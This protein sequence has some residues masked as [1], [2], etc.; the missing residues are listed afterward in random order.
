[1]PILITTYGPGLLRLKS[2]NKPIY[3]IPNPVDASIES[4]QAFQ[5]SHH[6]DLFIALGA[7]YPTFDERRNTIS[8]IQKVLPHLK[9]AVHI[10]AEKRGIWGAHYY[11]VLK[12]CKSGLNLS[13]KSERNSPP[14]TEEDF[15]LYSS[16]RISHYVGNGLLTYSD[17][18]FSL[19]ELFKREEEMVFYSTLKSWSR[20]LYSTKRMMR[21]GSVLLKMVGES[22]Q[23]FQ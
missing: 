6:W 7:F 5:N 3:Y 23:K 21:L 15:Y 19:H 14:G 16:D 8:H 1:M 11:D 17:E 9:F 22:P 18:A 20:K 13:R 4:S 12:T 2:D 10:L